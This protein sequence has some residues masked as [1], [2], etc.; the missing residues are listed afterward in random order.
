M[1]PETQTETQYNYIVKSLRQ[2]GNLKSSKK[3][4]NFL[5][6]RERYITDSLQMQGYTQKL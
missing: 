3:N 2:G 5:S 6:T 4:P 1:N